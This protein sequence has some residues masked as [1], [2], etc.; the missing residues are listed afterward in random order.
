MKKITVIIPVYNEEKYLPKVFDSLRKQDYPQEL[1]EIIVVDGCSTDGSANLLKKFQQEFRKLIVL[2]NPKKIVPVSMN[3]AIR[4]ATGEYLIRWDSHTLYENDYLSKCVSFLEGK[5]EVENVGGPMRLVTTNKVQEAIKMATTSIFGIGN[6]SFH[7]EDYQGFADT[8]Y[9]GAYRRK[10]FEKIGLFDE[11][12]V[13]NQDDELNYRLVK[14]GGKIFI[15]PEIKSYYYP[16]DSLKKLWKQYYEYGYWKVRVIQKHRIP[17]SIRHLVPGTF[18]LSLICGILLTPLNGLGLI[19][20][21]PV[22]TPYLSALI[23]FSLKSCRKNKNKNIFL[24]MLVFV[25]LHL[26]YGFGFLKGLI[27]F[28]G[29]RK[30]IKA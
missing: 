24:L 23:Y 19:I 1:T 14:S 10:I 29:K 26:S 28:W 21:V 3:L 9:L 4:Q 5:P 13:R 7:F 20:L 22:L 25:I 30:A 12:L 18:V 2:E 17:A 6:S 16:R 8:V 15:S 27:D 11:E